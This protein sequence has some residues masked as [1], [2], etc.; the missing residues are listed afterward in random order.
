[1]VKLPVFDIEVRICLMKTKKVILGV[2]LLAA[3]LLVFV[4]CSP[5]SAAPG[6]N[7]PNCRMIR[8]EQ[9]EQLTSN[10]NLY[11]ANLILV[12]DIL[13]EQEMLSKE[14]MSLLIKANVELNTARQELKNARTSLQKAEEALKKLSESYSLLRLQ[15]A[16]ERK[17]ALKREREAYRKGWLNGFCTG[18]VITGLGFL[19]NNAK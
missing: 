19:A 7:E 17:E 16:N 3:L 9:W 1:M 11:E 13:T 15:I 18:A 6:K 4:S 10:I 5:C 12:Q 2:C 14:L 8:T